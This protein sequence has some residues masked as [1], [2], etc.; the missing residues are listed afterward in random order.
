MQSICLTLCSLG[1]IIYVFVIM[2][3]PRV[4]ESIRDGDRR[5]QF[6]TIDVLTHMFLL[7]GTLMEG[8]GIDVKSPS[9]HGLGVMADVCAQV[10]FET[11]EL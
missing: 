3:T 6:G 7:D 11:V 8:T 4:S 1:I 10:C 5:V 2:F 9:Y